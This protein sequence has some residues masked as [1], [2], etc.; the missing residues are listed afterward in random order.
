MHN[1][2]C[3]DVVRRTALRLCW[4]A[5]N[6]QHMGVDILN[7]SSSSS[8][9][10]HGRLKVKKQMAYEGGA[11]PREGIIQNVFEARAVPQ[12]SVPGTAVLAIKRVFAIMLRRLGRQTMRGSTTTTRWLTTSIA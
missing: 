8:S 4:A 1:S 10:H 6:F 2:A 9:F 3:T 11:N 12:K 5:R 7:S